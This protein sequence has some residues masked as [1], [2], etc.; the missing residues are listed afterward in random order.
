MISPITGGNARLKRELSELSFRNE[1]Y[2]YIYSSYVCEDNMNVA[3][4]KNNG[5][6]TNSVAGNSSSGS[7]N[8]TCYGNGKSQFVLG[9]ATE[10]GVNGFIETAQLKLK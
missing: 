10:V 7:S 2:E 4:W 9:Y 3:V 1:R 5:V 6:I 8:G